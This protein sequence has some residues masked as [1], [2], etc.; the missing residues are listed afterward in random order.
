MNYPVI[1]LYLNSIKYKLLVDTGSN[2]TILFKFKSNRMKLSLK[3]RWVRF[4]T[5]LL[6][7][8]KAQVILRVNNLKLKVP[9]LVVDWQKYL[10][11]AKDIVKN[12]GIYMY[13]QKFPYDGILGLDLLKHLT[14]KIDCSKNIC[15]LLPSRFSSADSINII[16]FKGHIAIKIFIDNKEY[17]SFL[18][19]GINF[20]DIVIPRKR[21]GLEQITK[22]YVQI[23]NN[24]KLITLYK[25][26]KKVIVLNKKFKNLK[27]AILRLIS[28]SNPIIC[29]PLL[30]KFKTI[31]LRRCKKLYFK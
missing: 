1:N 4:K 7:S 12:I 29:Y 28:A 31:I 9:V 20:C 16:P 13:F 2:K 26:N 3:K 23:W 27:C 6:P 25:F 17:L 11:Y 19:T 5:F 30:K 15:C 22:K 8:Y 24:K 21:N 10:Q 14:L 18:D